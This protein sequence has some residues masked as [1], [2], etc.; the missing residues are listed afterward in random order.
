[1]HR[2]GGDALIAAAK[3]MN[4]EF[5]LL[6][7]TPDRIESSP[8]IE[9][10]RDASPGGQR[11]ADAYRRA[12]IFCL[13][14]R[15]DCTPVVLAEAMAAGLPVITTGIGSNPETVTDAVDGF[16]VRIDDE[17]AL[18][19]ALSTLVR[20]PDLRKQMGAAA[21]AKAR[22]RFDA[23]ANAQRIFALMERVAR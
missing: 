5:D 7:V 23:A 10:V 20:E 18:D 4:H 3:R 8:G 14:T 17:H 16:I 13:P 21:R 12:D 19:S 6:L 1:L 2:K 15:G 9:V 22:E 11:L